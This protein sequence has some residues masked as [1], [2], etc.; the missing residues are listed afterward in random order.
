[1]LQNAEEVS[2]KKTKTEAEPENGWQVKET[3]RRAAAPDITCSDGR[4]CAPKAGE[5]FQGCR[6]TYWAIP[7]G[8][9]LRPGFAGELVGDLKTGPRLTLPF[10]WRN[11]SIRKSTFFPK[12]ALIRVK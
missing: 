7:D 9:L 12:T 11:G 5:P 1:M 10:H 2:K 4:V 6:K 8:Q 3:A